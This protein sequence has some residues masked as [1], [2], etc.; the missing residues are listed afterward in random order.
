MME[1]SKKPGNITPETT[2]ASL[3]ADAQED[4][5]ALKARWRGRQ[6]GLVGYVEDQWGCAGE[7][8]DHFPTAVACLS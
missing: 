7:N 2:T 5:D 1:V 4:F 3:M 8:M 6:S